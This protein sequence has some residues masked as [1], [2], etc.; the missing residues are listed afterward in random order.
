LAFRLVQVRI[1]P[2]D[3]GWRLALPAPIATIMRLRPGESDV[4]ALFLHGHIEF[5]TIEALRSAV[6][7]PLTDIL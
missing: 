1:T 2:P 3:P 7:V 5:W 4:E 6:T